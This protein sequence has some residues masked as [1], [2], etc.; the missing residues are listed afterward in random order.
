MPRGG[1]Q[2]GRRMTAVGPR[3]RATLGIDDRVDDREQMLVA[4]GELVA[5][6]QRQ[7]L[8]RRPVSGLGQGECA[9][10]RPQLSHRGGGPD[11]TPGDVAHHDAEPAVRQLERVVPIATNLHAEPGHL[12]GGGQRDAGAPGEALGNQPALELDRDPVLLLVQ[13]GAPDGERGAVGRVLESERSVRAERA[14]GREGQAEAADIRSL[15][16][17]RHLR[18]RS[19]STASASLDSAWT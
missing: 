16:H 1:A 14:S 18:Q 8:A 11:A 17:Q 19:S 2:Q 13:L 12:V 3:D 7:R 10:Q 4:Q 15:D 5:V 6:E 9:R